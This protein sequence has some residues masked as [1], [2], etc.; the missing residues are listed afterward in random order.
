MT[1]IFNP[2]DTIVTLLRR[3]EGFDPHPYLDTTGNWT[4]GFGRNISTKGITK[5]EATY[6]LMNDIADATR[7]VLEN[8]PQAHGLSRERL[9]VL[10]MMCFNMGLFGVLG[11]KKMLEA[12]EKKDFQKAASEMLASRWCKQV[13][14][15][16][17]YL[18]EIML[19]GK[20]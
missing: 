7:Q 8:I 9:S 20:Y 10:V 18:A 15:R 11:F 5:D 6:L 17:H 2:D 4:I 16:A 19:T 3:H 14:A 13:G 1:T 12:I